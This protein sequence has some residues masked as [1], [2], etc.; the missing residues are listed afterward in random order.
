MADKASRSGLRYGAPEV[1][2]YVARLHAPHDEALQRAFDAPEGNGMPPIQVGPSEGR[3][4][5]LL[6]CMAGAK[7]VVEIG[8][9][10][11]YSAIWLARAL[12]EDGRLW[13]IERE[14][15]HAAVA[16]RNIEGAGLSRRVTVLEGEGLDIL[17]KLEKEG[18]FD[19]VFIDADKGSYD[20]YGRWAAAH[21]RRGGL[22]L[23][24][25]AF[26]FGQLMEDSAEARAVRRLHEEV[27]EFFETVCIGTGDGLLMGIRR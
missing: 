27:G 24:D 6:L 12:P 25:N 15:R 8:A 17:P 21:L 5:H 10:A 1:L 13:S 3:L 7:R 9:L 14:P 2:E 4:M 11:G 22:L 19:A 23:A 18:P 16:R 20:R 26:L